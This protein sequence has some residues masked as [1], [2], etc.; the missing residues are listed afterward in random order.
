M[1]NSAGFA[2]LTRYTKA[3]DLFR[4]MG[5]SSKEL[6]HSNILP[7]FMN[8]DEAHGLGASVRDAFVTSLT[9]LLSLRLQSLVIGAVLAHF[10]VSIYAPVA[11]SH[12]SFSFGISTQRGAPGR[13]RQRKRV[14][15]HSQTLRR[16]RCRNPSVGAFFRR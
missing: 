8:A 16:L 11:Y 1:R 6:V 12:C 15:T 9:Q 10:E 7:A 14:C 13:C 2:A 4:V 3:F 5:V